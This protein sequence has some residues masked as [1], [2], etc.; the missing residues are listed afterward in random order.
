MSDEELEDGRLVMKEEVYTTMAGMF[1]QGYGVSKYHLEKLKISEE[2]VMM[3]YELYNL[4][5]EYG[6]ENVVFNGIFVN[7]QGKKELNYELTGPKITTKGHAAESYRM[8]IMDVSDMDIKIK[9][10]NYGLEA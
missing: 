3:L 5:D 10:S 9:K 2:A 1:C 4:Y 6:R 7:S 8:D